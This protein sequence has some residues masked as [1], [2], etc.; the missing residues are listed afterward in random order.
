MIKNVTI[1]QKYNEDK[2]LETTEKWDK[3]EEFKVKFNDLS[4]SLNYN[5]PFEAYNFAYLKNKK[6]E[7]IAKVYYEN[8]VTD[9]DL[10]IFSK[11]ISK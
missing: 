10:L 6:G 2:E 3:Y 4:F 11:I 7:T 5:T 1:T 8:P 9:K